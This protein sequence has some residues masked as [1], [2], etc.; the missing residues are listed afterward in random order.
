MTLQ[1]RTFA[2]LAFAALGC[3]GVVAGLMALALFSA[4]SARAQGTSITLAQT[5]TPSTGQAGVTFN[6][7]Y[8]SNFPA[9]T[10]PP[11]NVTVSFAPA[12]GASGPSATTL[13]AAVTVISGTLERVTSPIPASIDVK[14]PTSYGVSVS[15]TTAGGAAFS[16]ANTAL[17]TIDPP[18]SVTLK[19]N[20]AQP[21]Q[22]LSVGITGTFTNFISGITSA[23][24]GAGI[25]VAGSPDGQFGPVA[26]QS[27]TSATAS[28][29]ISASAA[30]GP[31]TVTIMSGTQKATAQF[32][33]ATGTAAAITAT[34]G[35][36]QSAAINTA[37]AQL[38][39]ATVT[40]SG[41]NPVSGVTVT[42]AVPSTGASGSFAGGVTTAV[43]NA[44]GVA[45]SAVF[46][47]NGTVGSYTV[48]VTAA[49]VAVSSKFSLTNTAGTA[50]KL[51]FSVEP[52][53]AGAGSAITPAVQV[54][55]E[56]ASGNT[57]TSA[58]NT[59]SIAISN[60]PSSGTLA[61][62]LTASPVNGVATFWNL[63]INKLGTGYTLVASATGLTS[64]TSS[65]FNV[66]AGTAAK[67]VFSVEP[68]N[69]GAGSAITPAVQVTIED[70]SGNTVT[71]ATNTVSIAISNN[72]SS[73]TLAGTLTASPVN[74]VATFSNLSINKLGTGYTLVASATGLTSATSSAFNV[75]SVNVLLLTTAGPTLGVNRSFG[76][77]VALSPA[78][79]T[80][81]VTV[82]L[83]SANT[84]VVTVSPASV[85]VPA[86]G[87]SASF[88]L[89]G[90]TPGGPITLTATAPNYAS[91]TAGVTVTSSLISLAT[92]LV[93]APGQTSSLAFSLS[94]PAPSGG[95]VVNFVSDNTGLA[96]ITSSVTVPQGSGVATT[97]PHV[98][99]LA[100]GTAP[101]TATAIGF[102]QDTQPVQVT[103]TAS[104]ASN[105]VS[106]NAT[107]TV[108]DQLNISAAAPQPNGITFRL[109]VFNT[110]IATVP[111]SVSVPAGQLSIQNPITGVAIGS[112]NLTVSSPGISTVTGTIDVTAAPSIIVNALTV[113]NDLETAGSISLGAAVP[114]SSNQQNPP[115]LTLTAT[116][117]GNPSTH[118]LLSSSPT[119]VGLTSLTL[120][121]TPGSSAV[122][123]FY[124]QGRGLA[125][126][127]CP[128]NGC[129]AV[130]LTATASG[131]SNGSGTVTV[132]PSG[133]EFANASF[134]TTTFS[135]P[136][137]LFALLGAM[138]ANLTQFVAFTG[139]S[140][141][142]Q[143]GAS[144]SATVSSASTNVGTITNSGTL[145]WTV[146]GSYQSS[147]VSFQPVTAGTSTL[148]L[149]TPTGFSTAPL[150]DTQITATVTP[151]SITVNALTVGN[152][153]ETTGSVTLGA[154]VPSNAKSPTLTLTATE[155]GNPSTH[156]LLSSSPTSVGL[157]SLTLNLTPG[158][159]AVPTFYVQGRGL[160][161]GACPTNGCPAVALTATASG[162]SN[163]SGT[164]TVLPSGVEFA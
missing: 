54:T 5:T 162:Y 125:A 74:G 100:I 41:G 128:T 153:L 151:S 15:G 42:F 23:N 109:S 147:G 106:V 91:G 124:V 11:G 116:E 51:V 67:L 112:T 61:G 156:L 81:G 14:A 71:S 89:T 58:T 56:D 102:A 130:T 155:S 57:V 140:L 157:T 90:I 48:I 6:N 99:G 115:T 69:A 16:S 25:A 118:L 50:A 65:A 159:S 121:L 108:D 96:T 72:P 77:T 19:P 101:I 3:F 133:V 148:S 22:K 68:S 33:V 1:G 83:I 53:N 137:G 164:V 10:I 66:T 150:A 127:A 93:V 36:P 35:T 110:S 105:P 103:V 95:V 134:T 139:Q 158:S 28:L 145:T 34:S 98:T 117:S 97:D 161:A 80:G 62:T 27:A 160:A 131:Y 132:L 136:T 18:A 75:T 144:I 49:G 104:L 138:N 20:S 17:I 120:N 43:T 149:S 79:P 40:D 7:V 114:T 86:G 13:A 2:R 123:T 9:G 52:S 47:A 76:A 146:G 45:T 21:G 63:S 64:A 142:P 44:S 39:A 92:N 163:G 26:V 37:F 30:L 135:S 94:S 126:G 32:T 113:G 12:P 46:T 4:D 129:P 84:G 85:T 141:G 59:V 29:Q 38:L 60:N 107:R 73:G 154:N 55:I 111:A 82:T 143:A 70:A 122:P 119:A 8:G 152:G 78:A 87:T 88:T 24:F 31:R